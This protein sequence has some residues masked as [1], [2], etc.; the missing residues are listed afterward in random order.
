MDLSQDDAPCDNSSHRATKLPELSLPN[1]CKC[2]RYSIVYMHFIVKNKL[3]QRITRLVRYYRN[4][5]PS[6]LVT[7]ILK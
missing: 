6:L 7:R 4:V 1:A 2:N 5:L 3:V